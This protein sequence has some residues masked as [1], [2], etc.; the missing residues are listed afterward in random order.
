M[1]IELLQTVIN[2]LSAVTMPIWMV[3]L[4]NKQDLW[5]HDQKAVRRHYEDGDYR[6]KVAEL[7]KAIGTRSFQHELL[8]VSFAMTNLGSDDGDLFARTN[9]GYDLPTH[10]R[11]LQ[12]MFAR[13]HALL[14]G[15]RKR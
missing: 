12:S 4:V 1:E 5:W 2:G 11:Y 9:A 7:E 15:G 10:L 8:P 14:D 3:T 6:D 13:V